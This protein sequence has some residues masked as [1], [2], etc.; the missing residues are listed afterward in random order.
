MQTILTTATAG[1]R[2]EE[3]KHPSRSMSV[4]CEQ[5]KCHPPQSSIPPAVVEYRDF[6]EQPIRLIAAKYGIAPATLITWARKAHVGGRTRGRRREPRP[7]VGHRKIINMYTKRS[8]HAIARRVGVSPQ[9]VY[10]ILNRW[11]H[12]L[13][14]GQRMTKEKPVPISR[15]EIR[16]R[17]VSFRLTARQAERVKELLYTMGLSKRVSNS[18][19]C[20]VVFLAMLG[21]YGPMGSVLASGIPLEIR[22]TPIVAQ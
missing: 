4:Y 22:S 11:K 6:P 13:P 15:R 19:A 21:G 20:R 7:S 12:L 9:R 18:R 10:K 1:N 2:V 5:T 8:G 16:N 17:I 14:A 3:N